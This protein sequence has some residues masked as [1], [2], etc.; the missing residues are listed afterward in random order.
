MS[1]FFPQICF[2]VQWPEYSQR[3]LSIQ[4][5]GRGGTLSSRTSRGKDTTERLQHLRY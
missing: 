5:G 1:Q 2:Q 3:E 4:G